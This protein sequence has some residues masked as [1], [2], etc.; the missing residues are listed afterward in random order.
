[1]SYGVGTCLLPV[2]RR[3]L[4]GSILATGVYLH[5]DLGFKPMYHKIMLKLE[6][7]AKKGKPAGH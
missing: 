6:G 4:L 5:Y 1:M 3:V 2:V 7:P